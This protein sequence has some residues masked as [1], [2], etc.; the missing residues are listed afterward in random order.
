MTRSLRL[1]M[2]GNVLTGLLALAMALYG[3]AL[4]ARAQ[5]QGLPP[6]IPIELAQNFFQQ[7]A[8]TYTLVP[9]DTTAAT[10]LV[11]AIRW[12]WMLFGATPFKA[13]P[14]VT[15]GG[16]AMLAILFRMMVPVMVVTLP[17]GRISRTQFYRPP[18]QAQWD[19]ASQTWMWEGGCYDP[20]TQGICN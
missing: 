9:N 13:V 4:P 1:R 10:R 15:S 16:E 11:E 5:A 2:A 20:K 18:P 19:A 8:V 12:A 6:E 17:P 7:G 14:V 3:M